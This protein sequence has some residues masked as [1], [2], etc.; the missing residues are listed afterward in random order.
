MLIAEA[1]QESPLANHAWGDV[2]YNDV[3]TTV[4]FTWEFVLH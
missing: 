1:K 2:F 3:L 4:C